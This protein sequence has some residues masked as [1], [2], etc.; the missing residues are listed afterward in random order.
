MARVSFLADNKRASGSD[1][2]GIPLVTRTLD[3]VQVGAQWRSIGHQTKPDR[4]VVGCYDLGHHVRGSGFLV[5]L[6]FTISITHM[7]EF[8]N[9]CQP[10]AAR[11]NGAAQPIV[12]V[13][14]NVSIL[15][16]LCCGRIDG[17]YATG[18]TQY[19]A[20]LAHIA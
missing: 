10:Y 11:R 8:E 4:T 13:V 5:D 19:Y 9:K 6:P 3:G 20:R 1:P 15:R 12:S 17:D 18:N 16:L 14:L 7:G 2:A